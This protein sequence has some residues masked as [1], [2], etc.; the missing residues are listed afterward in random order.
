MRPRLQWRHNARDGVLNHQPHDCL[1]NHLFRRRSKKTSKFHVT[2]PLCGEFTGHREF[3]TQRVSK[4]FPFDDVIIKIMHT[5]R[6]FVWFGLL[7][8]DYRPPIM[9]VCMIVRTTALQQLEL[10]P[11][12]CANIDWVEWSRFSWLIDVILQV[13]FKLYTKDG[14]RVAQ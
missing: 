14:A 2:G 7:L 3:P 4:M 6:T 13:I 9:Y 11:S 12:S 10:S 8:A 1:L 5:V